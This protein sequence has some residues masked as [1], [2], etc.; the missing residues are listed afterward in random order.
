MVVGHPKTP[1]KGIPSGSISFM[2][3]WLAH[4]LRH[5]FCLGQFCFFFALSRKPFLSALIGSLPIILL[6]GML[7]WSKVL[8]VFWFFLWTGFCAIQIYA[9][10]QGF[11]RSFYVAF[12]IHALNNTSIALLDHFL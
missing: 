5:L 4:L 12:V 7:G 10:D 11:W 8:I 6:H 2:G 1:S 3:D 9:R